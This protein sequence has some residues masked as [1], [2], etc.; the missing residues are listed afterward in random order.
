MVQGRIAAEG[1]DL[2]QNYELLE[3]RILNPLRR[4]PGVARVD[5]DGVEPRELFVD[6]ILDKVKEHRV[7]VGG[8]AQLLQ[9]VSA[10]LVLGRAESGG[11]RY[12]V[13]A[14]GAFDSIEALD[15]LVIDERG[16]APR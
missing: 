7:D 14:L 8:L 10:N 1:V 15:N 9:S 11:L 2:S 16:L 12:T 5:L 4:V 13:R 6:L 3:A